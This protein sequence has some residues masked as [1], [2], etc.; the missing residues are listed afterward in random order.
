M[1]CLACPHRFAAMQWKK[2]DGVRLE[3]DCVHAG[4]IE[5][6]SGVRSKEKSGGKG[7]SRRA[8]TIPPAGKTGSLHGAY[9]AGHLEGKSKSV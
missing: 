3:Q 9:N 5:K 2:L 7:Y 4:K 1:K 8:R 6:E